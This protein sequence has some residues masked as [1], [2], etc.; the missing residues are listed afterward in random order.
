MECHRV[1]CDSLIALCGKRNEDLKRFPNRGTFD[2]RTRNVLE[3]DVVKRE[4]GVPIRLID[5]E[6]WVFNVVWIRGAFG[7]HDGVSLDAIHSEHADGRECEF[8]T[9]FGK[10]HRA[11]AHGLVEMVN[12]RVACVI[13][14]VR[15]QVLAVGSTTNICMDR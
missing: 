14:V 2:F 4:C 13:A 3:S 12:F 11:I 8:G 5:R 10:F 7:S 1:V 6:N 15:G 9:R